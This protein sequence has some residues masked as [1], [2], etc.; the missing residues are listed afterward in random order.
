MRKA[1][2]LLFTF[3][4]AFA[5]LLLSHT[6][7]A[8]SDQADLA[9]A[10]THDLHSH[11]TPFYR[12]G[13]SVGGMAR[14][15][16]VIDNI[17]SK[18]ANSLV[19]DGGDFS[20]GTL[21]QT[22]F[23]TAAIE[24]RMLGS[25]GYDATTFGNHEFDYGFDSFAEMIDV[26]NSQSSPLPSILCS[27]INTASSDVSA[28]ELDNI[29]PYDVF[30][31]GKYTIAVFGLLG[32]DAVELSTTEPLVFSD[33]IESA[34]T[35]VAEIE[36]LYS[37]D[38]LICLSHSGTGETVNDEDIKLAEEVPEIDLI[39]SGHTH[40][41]LY[42][43]IYVGDT[44]IASCGEYGEY[45]G[46]ILF[47]E[48]NDK[49]TLKSYTLIKIDDSIAAD[50]DTDTI[51]RSFDP[52]ISEYLAHFG[53]SSPEEIISKSN[54]DFTEQSIMSEV[55]AE[56]PLGNLISDSYIHAVKNAEG[57]DYIPIDV[58][59][60][61]SGVIRDTISRGN[62][63]VSQIFEI[64][65][66]GIGPDGLAGYPLCSVYLYG[67]ELWTV[68]EIDASVSAIMPYAQLYSSG[69]HYS[70]NTNRMFLNR[71]YDCWLVDKNGKR[72]EIEDDKLYRV[73]S[74]ITSA[75]MLGTVKGK[76][77]GLLELTPKDSDGNPITDF[78][79]HIIKDKNGEEIKEW[80]ALADYI[81]SFDGNDGISVIPK[82]YS[83][84]EGRKNINNDFVFSEIFTNWNFI[85]WTV[86]LVGLL[87]LG[88]ITFIVI[89]IVRRVRKS[90]RLRRVTTSVDE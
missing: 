83:T 77:F 15:K 79:K 65:S 66:L 21:Y 49:L 75:E 73:V 25:L 60:V 72:I 3:F 61:P 62:I 70:V 78:D 37:P 17:R 2:I 42:D 22:A 44:I 54:F 51:I 58:A 12:N 9:I 33:F 59:T 30:K 29:K 74:G 63:T 31:K 87:L 90:K 6:A 16:T 56:Q 69:L 13:K 41:Y 71:V 4:F 24:Y 53:Y 67:S 27:N 82:N 68:A 35:T 57:D 7:S 36:K 8:S 46:E 86:M 11:V 88:I 1:F 84:V 48:K 81:A 26:A 23:T 55:L 52:L 5:P 32:R 39:I 18:S 28:S 76:S 64:S 38:L 14:I 47:D 10:F 80:K 45:V 34:K 85:T 89:L 43:P 50:P 20:M 40:S 19:V